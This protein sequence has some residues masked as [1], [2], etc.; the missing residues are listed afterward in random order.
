MTEADEEFVA[1]IGLFGEPVADPAA[2]VQRGPAR[3]TVLTDRLLRLEWSEH[4]RFEDRSSYAFPTR[5]GPVPDYRL[6]ER[7]GTLLLDTGALRLRHR[8]DGLPFHPGNLQIELTGMPAA[9]WVPGLR[10]RRNLGGARR[11]VDTCRGDAR[12]EPG[13]VSRS[14]WAVHDDAGSILFEDGWVSGRSREPGA[15]DW[16][17][18]GHG[19]DY[20]AAVRDYTAF[21]GG[22]P[23][24]PRWMLGA[25]W[26]RYWPYRDGELREL[27]EEFR[28]RRLPLDV[29]V[30]DM[31]WHLPDSWTGYTWNRELFPDPAGFLAWLHERRLHSTLN[32]HP[33]LGVQPFEEGYAAFAEAVAHDSAGAVPFRVTDPAFVRHYFELLHHPLEDDGVDFWWLDWQQ[34]RSFDGAGIDPLPWLNHLHFTDL[35][36]R[37]DRRPVT[38]SRWGGLGS[39]RYPIGFSGDSFAQWS[40]LRFQPRYTAAGANVG[41]GWWSHD[42]G[43][44]VGPDDPEL[45]VRWVQFGAVSP[46]L[47]LHSN[48][49]PES[50]RR[51]WIFGDE[52]L[53]AARAAFELRYALVPYLHTAAREAA[54]SGR[55]PVR[56]LSWLA[57]A[58]DNAYAARY[59]YLLGDDLVVAP[60]VHPADPATGLATVDVW[61]PPGEWV[62]RHTLELVTGPRWV[63]QLADL[64]R[65]PLFV[66]RGAVLPLAAPALS[67]ADQPDDHLILEV[68]PGAAGAGRHYLDDGAGSAHRSGQQGWTS[69]EAQAPDERSCLLTIRPGA[70]VGSRRYTVRLL[71][72]TAPAEVRLNGAP[73]AD[74]RQDGEV[75]VVELPALAG[76]SVELLVRAERALSVLGERRNRQVRRADLLR[77][78]G[79]LGDDPATAVLALPAEHPARGAAVGRLGGPAIRV[80]E[81][82]APDEAADT[83]GRLVIGVAPDERVTARCTWTLHRG[84]RTTVVD[85][86]PVPVAAGGEVFDA[87]FRWDDTLAPARWTVEVTAIWH[88]AH[89]DVVLRHRHESA[90]LNPSLAAWSVAITE[91]GAAEP[92]GSGWVCHRA[93]PSDPDFGELT[94]RYLL[95]V[96]RDPRAVP[97]RAVTVHART[98]LRAAS[99]RT[100]AF[101]YLASDEVEVL[102]DGV[103]IRPEV[104][105]NGPARFY[106][107]APA[108]RRTAAVRLTAG[109][110]ELVVRCAKAAELPWSQWCLAVEAVGTDGEVLLDLGCDCAENLD[111]GDVTGEHGTAGDGAAGLV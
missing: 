20:P 13:L 41:Y 54:D 53:A 46:I 100:V 18:F 9:R 101:R 84:G 93:E 48:Q 88:A 31:D 7:D 83:L 108:L 29:V 25:W 28:R 81:H 59:E 89:G 27:V 52:V 76:P 56:P 105:G 58:D 49:E 85:R 65:L 67:T 79:N 37:P 102:L 86:E 47:R 63:R 2:V 35:G 106:Q 42:I 109:E 40:A 92:A 78:L 10:D 34:G 21:G 38:F 103:P 26:S 22:V 69:F 70:G 72:T 15:L 1:R 44:H 75:T 77:L 110:H 45:Y 97:D 36:R 8:V 68:V 62:E 73:H 87:P 39:H 74:W 99:E 82:T 57:P 90:V 104:T 32:L 23:V 17:F 71:G 91:L 95:P 14:G 43:G 96:R 107:L 24:I 55:A 16:Y 6:D 111:T 64:H 12:L 98:R 33:A 61:L 11:T 19:H 50:E 4:G 60:A 3:F 30:I 94:G 5:R 51:P 80:D 66:R